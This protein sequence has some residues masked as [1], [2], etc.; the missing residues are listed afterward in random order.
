MQEKENFCCS[1]VVKEVGESDIRRSMWKIQSR[2][3]RQAGA[4]PQWVEIRVVNRVRWRQEDKRLRA[5]LVICLGYVGR[6]ERWT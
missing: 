4:G 2:K 1:K 6:K 5:S 3:V